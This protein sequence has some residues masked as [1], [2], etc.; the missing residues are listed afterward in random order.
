MDTENKY[1]L[2]FT[3]SAQEDLQHIF[4][5]ITLELSAETAAH[6]L[7]EKIEKQILLLRDFPFRCP[8]LTDV[9]LKRT[10]CR[11][12]V[13][14]NFVAIYYVDKEKQQIIIVGVFYG[15]QNYFHTAADRT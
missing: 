10:D 15:R 1:N 12:L 9:Q 8:I 3:P 7:M 11:R 14:D 13:I 4:D 5:Y 6:R 2:F